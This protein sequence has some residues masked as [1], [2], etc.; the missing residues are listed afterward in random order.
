MIE[1]FRHKGLKR[2]FQQ[3]D[4]KGISPE[5]LEKLE[6]ILFVLSRARRPEDM[7]LPGFGLHR[8]KGDFKGFW[9]VTVRAHSRVIFRFEEGDAHDVDLIDYH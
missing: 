7:N 6:N 1:R 4:A 2:L 5:L 9:S 3:G 8:L